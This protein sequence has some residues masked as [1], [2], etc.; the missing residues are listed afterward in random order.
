MSFSSVG[1]LSSTLRFRYLDARV[2]KRLRELSQEVVSGTA[3]DITKKIDGG[4]DLLGDLQRSAALL[5][6]YQQNGTEMS[7]RGQAMQVALEK[8][9]NGA[10]KLGHTLAIHMGPT[11]QTS[12]F[13]E[14]RA[15]ENGFR[16][17]I[18]T[19]NTQIAGQ[20]LFSGQAFQ[21]PAVKSADKILDDLQ[22]LTAGA[23]SASQV[24]SILDRYFDDP[25]GGYM[26]GAYLGTGRTANP[27]RI[28]ETESASFPQTAADP[29]IR[30]ALKGMAMAAL[31]GRGVL[32]GRNAEKSRLLAQA[33]TILMTANDGL[34]SMR[35]SIGVQ[36]ERIDTVRAENSARA[37][38]TQ[39]RISD[40]ISVDGY[41]AATDFKA[42]QL[43]LESLFVTTSRLS[44][45]SLTNYIR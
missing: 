1:D 8:L 2:S 38:K 40:M 7:T 4:V 30:K 9:Q 44:K 15:A 27:V 32:S 37:S 39:S 41:K 10:Q 25:A 34:T 16:A 28:S 43:Q 14:T 17:A 13:V 11:T 3:S 35:A 36:Q 31:L 20:T 12:I 45:L 26:S 6:T 33:G 18:G 5:K 24:Q 19:L 42:A 23:V 21:S 22:A 29:K